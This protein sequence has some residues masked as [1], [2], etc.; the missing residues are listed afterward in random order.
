MANDVDDP[1]R[2]LL[3]AL[4][5]YDLVTSYF[6]RVAPQIA[7]SSI[8]F[9]ASK[10]WIVRDVL[11]NFD[12][13]FA[14]LGA[15]NAAVQKQLDFVDQIAKSQAK[16]AELASR[17]TESYRAFDALTSIKFASITGAHADAM[18]RL[19]SAFSS[20]KFAIDFAARD[21]SR[22][23]EAVSAASRIQDRLTAVAKGVDGVI[24]E[25]IQA[26]IEAASSIES[27]LEEAIESDPG[28]IGPN[29]PTIVLPIG[30]V[31]VLEKYSEGKLIQACAIP[32]LEIVREIERDANFLFRFVDH[33]ENFEEFLAASYDRAGFTV[34]LTPRSGD[35]GRDVIANATFPGVGAIRI[36]DQAKAY[37]PHR[38]VPAND[39]RAMLG[40]VGR[41]PN[42]SKGFISTSSRFAPGVIKEFAPQ[43]PTRLELRDGPKLRAWLLEIAAT[44]SDTGDKS[45]P[46]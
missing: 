39:V 10:T 16:Q 6:D 28:A 34:V 35:L 20:D 12:R 26:A 18:Q 44:N 41:D 9:E 46:E 42:V 5:Q 33:P 17:L 30:I 2:G 3:S 19:L 29:Q 31:S 22:H 25:K 40:V 32:W 1:G 4:Q 14:G 37:A 45:P 43:I 24:A 36:Y 23:V 13:Q 21:F 11:R 7:S 27:V 8:E 38:A 15:L